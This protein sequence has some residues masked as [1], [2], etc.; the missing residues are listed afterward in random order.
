MKIVRLG[1]PLNPGIARNS[2]VS[3]H[4]WCMAFYEVRVDFEGKP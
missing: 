2:V 3:E 1:Q 4:I